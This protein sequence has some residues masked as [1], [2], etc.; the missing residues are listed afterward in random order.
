[1]TQYRLGINITQQKTEKSQLFL[2]VDPHITS[3]YKYQV[4]LQ[5]RMTHLMY[6]IFK[7]KPSMF[8]YQFV[9]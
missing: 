5:D 6:K 2:E 4:Q 9:L 8:Q 3:K 7:N 1:M